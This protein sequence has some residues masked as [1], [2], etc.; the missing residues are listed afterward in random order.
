MSTKMNINGTT[1]Y[2]HST[3]APSRI[4]APISKAFRRWV[5]PRIAR[6][7]ASKPN[8]PAATSGMA[9]LAETTKAGEKINSV[10]AK[11]LGSGANSNSLDKR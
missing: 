9:R 4:P 11:K 2:R 3:A 5:Q 10:V 1:L 7:K 8:P 6:T